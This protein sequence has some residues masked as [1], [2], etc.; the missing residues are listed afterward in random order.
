MPK[1]PR[2]LLG[3]PREITINFV[4]PGEYWHNNLKNSIIKSLE[5]SKVILENISILVNIDGVPI[6]KSSKQQFWPILCSIFEM[7]HLSP[8]ICGIYLGSAKP[9]DLHE[10]LKDLLKKWAVCFTMALTLHY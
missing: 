10:F 2:S 1:D 7:P 6:H 3:T 4:D 9:K 8:I 5:N